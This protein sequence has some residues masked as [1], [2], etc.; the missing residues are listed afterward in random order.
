[1]VSYKKINNNGLQ[2][3]KL[4]LLNVMHASVA[5]GKYFG[6]I[7]PKPIKCLVNI[8]D[9]EFKLCSDCTD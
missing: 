3:A 5:N 8:V 7:Q 6:Y 2:F 1:M 4:G 9:K